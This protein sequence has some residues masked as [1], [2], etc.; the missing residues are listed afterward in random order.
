M[1]WKIKIY[2]DSCPNLR[3]GNILTNYKDICMISGKGF[4]QI[5]CS[6]EICPIKIKGNQ[7]L[8]MTEARTVLYKRKC[9]LEQSIIKYKSNEAQILKELNSCRNTIAGKKKLLQEIVDVYDRLT[10]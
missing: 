5:K 9:E 7:K 1:T 3:K 4:D 8:K 10:D 6:K 2:S